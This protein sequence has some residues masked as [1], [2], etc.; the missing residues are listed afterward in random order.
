MTKKLGLLT[1][2]LLCYSMVFASVSNAAVVNYQGTDP[3]AGAGGARPNSNAGAEFFG[4][5]DNTPTYDKVV[6]SELRLGAGPSATRDIRGMDD[7][8]FNSVPEPDAFVLLGLGLLGLGFASRRS[9]G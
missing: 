2:T 4:F 3:G 6:F 9:R 5:I 7:I 1:G 8:H